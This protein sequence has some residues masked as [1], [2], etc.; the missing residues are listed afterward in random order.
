MRNRSFLFVSRFYTHSLPITSDADF[1][2]IRHDI[3]AK[4]TG[5]PIVR[6]QVDRM[7]NK[8]Q[9]NQYVI[10]KKGARVAPMILKINLS[11]ACIFYT[12]NH[13]ILVMQIAVKMFCAFVL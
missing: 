10:L 9:H 13:Y 8:R 6:G 11:S 5:N 3:A 4:A 2:L 1:G 12:A 7:R